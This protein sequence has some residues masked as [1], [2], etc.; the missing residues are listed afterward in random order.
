M[1][2]KFARA[3]ADFK[4]GFA[5]RGASGQRAGE[6]SMVAHQRVDDAQV[7]PAAARIR[8]IVRQRIQ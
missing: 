7:A 4:D 3:R 6:P 8:M 5:G 1:Q 2:R